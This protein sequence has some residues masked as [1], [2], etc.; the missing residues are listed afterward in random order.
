[1]QS[2]LKMRSGSFNLV[3][4]PHLFQS[5]SPIADNIY[6]LLLNMLS[7]VNPLN[8]RCFECHAF[9]KNKKC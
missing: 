1:M 4:S 2:F 9:K 6:K 3:L 5:P 7:E 8:F